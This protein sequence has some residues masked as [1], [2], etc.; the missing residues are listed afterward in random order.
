MPSTCQIKNYYHL[1]INSFSYSHSCINI[2]NKLCKSSWYYL[3]FSR[4]FSHFWNRPPNAAPQ[5]RILGAFISIYIR[6]PWF[7]LSRQTKRYLFTPLWIYSLAKYN[8]LAAVYKFEFVTGFKVK[9]NYPSTAFLEISSCLLLF[10]VNRMHLYFA[11]SS[12]PY[13]AFS[14]FGFVMWSLSSD[15]SLLP[16]FRIAIVPTIPLT[17]AAF[18]LAYSRP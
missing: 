9:S 3:L 14:T 18:S 1:T 4:T 2:V 7:W 16:I 11:I 8:K 6:P 15:V 12:S 5:N 17:H 13:C 10:L